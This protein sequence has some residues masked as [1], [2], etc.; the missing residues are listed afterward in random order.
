[1]LRYKLIPTRQAPVSKGALQVVPKVLNMMFP[2][3]VG[4]PF[5]VK[6][7]RNSCE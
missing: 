1:M 2:L 3:L 4:T 5:K 6:A 7:V